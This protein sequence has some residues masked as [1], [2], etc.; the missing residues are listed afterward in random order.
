MESNF[1][2][3]KV[4]D[5]DLS[6]SLEGNY[7]GNRTENLDKTR[8]NKKKRT[9]KQTGEKET[10]DLR[11]NTSPASETPTFYS[12]EKNGTIDSTIQKHGIEKKSF[13][14]RFRSN[15]WSPKQSK[16][17]EFDNIGSAEETSQR[18]KR[19]LA[20]DELSYTQL[21]YL[22]TPR[23]RSVSPS[24]CNEILRL[25]DNCE[26]ENF[27]S[28]LDY[29][30]N[31]LITEKGNHENASGI[32]NYKSIFTTTNLVAECE[33]FRLADPSS[34]NMNQDYKTSK[35]SDKVMRSCDIKCNFENS[36][37]KNT[38]ERFDN[39]NPRIDGK[40]RTYDNT[41]PR[42]VVSGH[43]SDTS[44]SQL[45]DYGF[46]DLKIEDHR[47]ENARIEDHKFNDPRSLNPR[48]LDQRKSSSSLC[49]RNIG[50]L[51]QL[52]HDDCGKKSCSK[53]SPSCARR[54]I[55][56]SYEGL[57]RVPTGKVN[58]VQSRAWQ[59]LR[60]EDRPKSRDRSFTR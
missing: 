27:N 13:V 45:E 3:L 25:D 28:I 26:F 29:Q 22:A 42:I 16:S 44:K 51:F 33:K 7:S 23:T 12:R 10:G 17:P 34:K 30:G 47:F 37:S 38:W 49:S 6:I 20:L 21:L 46:E 9:P 57:P 55:G 53:L 31:A 4:S 19:K 60:D 18:E 2:R 14:S 8:R 43:R 1:T 48:S 35:G 54:R 5:D 11:N 58:L 39:R 15:T 52:P 40:S 32:R 59:R 50:V 36:L 24:E 41:S 56:S